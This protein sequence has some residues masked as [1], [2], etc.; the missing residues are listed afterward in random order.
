MAR[1]VRPD[2][3]RS[4]ERAFQRA[5]TP[6]DRALE[7]SVLLTATDEVEL[8]SRRDRLR[9][10]Y[11]TELFVMHPTL[12][13]VARKIR[14]EVGKTRGASSQ[15][16]SLN[17]QSLKPKSLSVDQIA[18]YLELIASH[19]STS[20]TFFG[21]PGNMETI[22]YA[23]YHGPLAKRAVLFLELCHFEFTW[24]DPLFEEL[25]QGLTQV[26]QTESA[27]ERD[28][29]AYGLF[30]VS[31]RE[32]LKH[33]R[34]IRSARAGI[35][36]IKDQ[37]MNANVRLVRSIA[38]KY[39]GLGAELSDLDQAGT[40]GLGRAVDKFNINRGYKFSTY[41]TWWI[42]QAVM[43]EIQMTRSTI[44]VPAHKSEQIAKV[45]RARD[46][47]AAQGL[48][49]DAQSIAQELG[50]T[51]E[52]VSSAL[53]A[54]GMQSLVRLDA[55][56]GD[57]GDVTIGDM[58]PDPRRNG[59]R[60]LDLKTDLARVLE[61][62]GLTIREREAIDLRFGLRDGEHRTLEATGGI[63]GITRERVRQLEEKALRKLRAH[64][65][66]M[67]LHEFLTEDK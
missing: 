59:Q 20:K 62:A 53:R 21:R 22:R 63:L 65:Y 25:E 3:R 67:G 14:R 32:C 26:T 46:R 66:Q 47:L 39:V 17:G 49:V 28:V 50:I 31:G 61:R 2:E 52:V 9:M 5:N 42:K 43:R 30:R 38:L 19:M 64:G 34:S 6:F 18:D 27:E 60:K 51:E 15:F 29:L 4:W 16:Q 45:L 33:A 56:I 57:D 1:L 8:F 35:R 12:Y 36:A 7:A 40:L 48:V 55:P 10:T 24:F 13:A 23:R 54:L 58:T 44:Q 41:A 11:L 37:V